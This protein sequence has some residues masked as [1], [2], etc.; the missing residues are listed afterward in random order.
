MDGNG[1]RLSNVWF[2]DM[3]PNG[4]FQDFLRIQNKANGSMKLMQKNPE[5]HDANSTSCKVSYLNKSSCQVS[6]LFYWLRSPEGQRKHIITIIV[7]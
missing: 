5:C 6:S 7:K 3:G 4:K 2:L 1:D